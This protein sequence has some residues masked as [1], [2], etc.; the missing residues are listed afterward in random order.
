MPLVKVNTSQVKRSAG[1]RPGNRIPGRFEVGL[2]EPPATDGRRRRHQQSRA[3]ILH[4]LA[5]A[6]SQPDIE[7]TP[8]QI[9][10][11]SG[12][13]L[14][15]I[16]RHFGGQQQLAEAM[17][18]LVQSRVREHLDA[19]PYEGDLSARVRELVHRLTAVSE[20]VAPFFRAMERGRER[21]EADA[22]RERLNDVVRQQIASALA[23]DLAALPADTTDILSTLL[24]VGAWRHMRTIQGLDLAR[25]TELLQSAAVRLLG[26]P[27]R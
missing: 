12:Y 11:R 18:E 3:R 6:L 24:S 7:I 5:D 23:G 4:A 27:L 10:A 17:R 25:A 15:T 19:G 21:A 8:E 2:D 1:G 13:S 16:F 9:A 22:G 20:T 26:P 14:S